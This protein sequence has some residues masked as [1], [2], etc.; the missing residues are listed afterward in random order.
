MAYTPAQNTQTQNIQTG[1]TLNT[2]HSN[3]LPSYTTSRNLFRPPL[4]T[5][6]TNPLSYS[7]TSTNPNSTQHSTTNNNQLNTLN[8]FSTSQ[9]SNITRNMLQ[10]TQFQTSN[11]PSTTIRTNPHI[12]STYTQP[13]TNTPNKSSNNSNKPTYNTVPPSTIP[14]SIVSHPTHINSSTTLSEPIKP[15]DGLDHNYTPEEYLQHF[16]ARVT[17]LLGLQKHLNTNISFGTFEE[18]LLYNAL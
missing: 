11:P 3:A 7:L 17:F 13:F 16:E 18:W 4:Q 6:P 9:S 8:P 10:N 15:F 12:N 2:H 1:V 14:K 5:I